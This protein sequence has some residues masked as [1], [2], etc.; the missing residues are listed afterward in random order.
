MNNIL[1]GTSWGE[2]P[3]KELKVPDLDCWRAEAA[4]EDQAPAVWQ[5][6]VESMQRGL[7]MRRRSGK[8]QDY[9]NC[10]AIISQLDGKPHLPRYMEK[11]VISVMKTE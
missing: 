10:W 4:I 3:E 2:P 9:M 5:A 1:N 8:M 11:S 7:R 6:C